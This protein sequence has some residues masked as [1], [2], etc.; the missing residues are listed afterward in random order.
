MKT[1]LFTILAV[2]ILSLF[3][4]TKSFAQDNAFIVENI[5]VEGKLDKNFLRDKY[6]NKAIFKSFK[7]LMSKILVSSDLLKVENVDLKK[8]KNL[9]NSFKILEEN[10]SKRKYEASFTINYN[11]RRVKKFLSDKNLSFSDPKKISAVF[12]P[13]FFV[14]GEVK[15][16][17][18][19]YFYQNWLKIEIK[20]ELINFILPIEDLDDLAKVQKLKNSIEDFDI[21]E[22]VGKYN[23]TNY[24]FLFMYYKNKKIKVHIKTNFENNPISK[25]FSYLINN[26]NDENKL[27]FILEDLKLKITDIWKESNYVNLLMPLSIRVKYKQND[28]SDLDNLKKILYKI[29]LVDDYVLEEIN[30]NY[31]FFKIYYFGSPKKLK[32]E[33]LKF[34]YNLEDKQGHWEIYFK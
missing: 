11:E 9:I 14:N 25:N 33:L 22:I 27:N 21:R 1:Y 6:I 19:N 34:G 8:I 3:S 13:A 24:V 7:K 16:F 20:N 2:T 10:Y 5:K 31:S 12:F 28:I 23:N 17:N 32:T 4:Y 29:G 18:D 26:I 15:S 30:V